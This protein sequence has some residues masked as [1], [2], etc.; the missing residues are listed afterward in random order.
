MRER[1]RK[2]E[3]KRERKK[4]RE[5]KREKERERKR[6]SEE[7]GKKS[8]REKERESESERN[9]EGERETLA[10]WV[11]EQWLPEHTAKE[12]TFLLALCVCHDEAA[13]EAACVLRHLFF[14]WMSH[15]FHMG[16]FYM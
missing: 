7:R 12:Q 8:E 1:K 14:F 3:R 4:E 13:A 16:E 2:K 9:L 11:R 10:E 5:R 15:D 6:E